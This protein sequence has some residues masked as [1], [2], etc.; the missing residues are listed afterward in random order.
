MRDATRV[1]DRADVS[2]QIADLSRGTAD[3][4]RQVGEIGRRIGAVESAAG[5]TLDKARAAT[6]PLG[7]EIATLG[8]LVKQLAESV[9]AHETV[10]AQVAAAQAGATNAAH[11]ASAPIGSTESAGIIDA[12]ELDEGEGRQPEGGGFG[13]FDRAQVTALIVSA[14]EGNRV[15][16]YLQPVVSLPQRKVR[17]YEALTR[18]RTE[19]GPVVAAGRLPRVRRSRRTDAAHRQPCC[20]SVA[21]RWCA[22]SPR[23]TAT[24]ACSATSRHRP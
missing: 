4:A 10:L 5:A 14:I 23:R 8:T 18:L 22:A 11:R 1:R 9:A 3:L 2:D 13:G 12:A 16:L 17:F 19:D 24:S 6:E 15:D 21:C 7:A 20:C